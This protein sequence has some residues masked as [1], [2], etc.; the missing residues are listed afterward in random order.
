MITKYVIYKLYNIVYYLKYTLK[1][2]NVISIYDK[3]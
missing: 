3:F 1:H 2:N